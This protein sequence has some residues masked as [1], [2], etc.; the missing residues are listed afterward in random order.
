MCI[1]A[2]Y[3]YI[4]YLQSYRILV[5][6]FNPLSFLK[7][8]G[9]IIPNVWNNVPKH[10]PGS[11]V[12]CNMQ[13]VIYVYVIIYVCNIYEYKCIHIKDYKCTNDLH[14]MIYIH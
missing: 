13:Y 6:G 2:K 5:G 3:V 8:V 7:S 1:Y 4:H 9:M 10:Q 12:K 11:Y 14:P